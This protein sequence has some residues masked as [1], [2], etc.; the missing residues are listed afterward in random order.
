MQ[1]Q[2][3]TPPAASPEVTV[4]GTTPAIAAIARRHSLPE[5]RGPFPWGVLALGLS[6]FLIATIAFTVRIITVGSDGATTDARTNAF[7]HRDNPASFA[8]YPKNALCF[9]RWQ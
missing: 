9:G 8:T 1:P 2:A 7:Q 5:R 3:T 4:P 6:F